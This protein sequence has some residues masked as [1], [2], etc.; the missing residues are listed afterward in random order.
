MFPLPPHSPHHTHTPGKRKKSR[1]TVDASLS[2][3]HYCSRQK[4]TLAAI[5]LVHF[6]GGLGGSTINITSQRSQRTSHATRY[7]F[8]FLFFLWYHLLMCTHFLFLVLCFFLFWQTVLCIKFHCRMN[9]VCIAVLH[10]IMATC[11]FQSHLKNPVVDVRIKS[12]NT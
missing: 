5:G 4:S 7:R 1:S 6:Y 12:L 3:R 11:I 2:S 10:E 9:I 8:V